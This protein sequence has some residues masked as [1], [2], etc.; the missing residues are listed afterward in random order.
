MK[1][2]KYET[3]ATYLNFREKEKHKVY[4][5]N[6]LVLH[7]KSQIKSDCSPPSIL[8]PQVPSQSQSI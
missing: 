5:L 7:A 2:K 3:K 4:Y 6:I 1:K 8:I